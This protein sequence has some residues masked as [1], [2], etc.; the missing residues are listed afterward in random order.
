MPMLRWDHVLRSM[1][2]VGSSE[3]QC[4]ILKQL[5]RERK[6]GGKGEL[7]LKTEKYFQNLTGK[8]PNS[9]LADGRGRR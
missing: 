2:Q 7:C 3:K 5:N 6:S 9:R 8:Y 4:L 1:Q